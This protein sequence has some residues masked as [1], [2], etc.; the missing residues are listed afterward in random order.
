[1]EGGYLYHIA[2]YIYLPRYV[3]IFSQLPDHP[4]SPNVGTANTRDTYKSTL[5]TLCT[6]LKL[7]ILYS[8]IL[9]T[10]SLRNQV[11]GV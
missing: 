6:N 2:I 9:L 11:R 7:H 8:F 1:M 10:K 4:R 5:S 3:H